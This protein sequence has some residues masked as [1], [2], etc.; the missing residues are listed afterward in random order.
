MNWMNWT[1]STGA[2]QYTNTDLIVLLFRKE[3]IKLD[4]LNMIIT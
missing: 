3:N 2:K 1:W 4:Q